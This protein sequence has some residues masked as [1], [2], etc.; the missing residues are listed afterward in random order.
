MKRHAQGL[1]VGLVCLAIGI[2]FRPI[3]VLI[4]SAVAHS[5]CPECE[6]RAVGAVAKRIQAER[7]AAYERAQ[8]AAAQV[9]SSNS[10]GAR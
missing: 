3:L 1:L 6:A 2:G 5:D 7:L 8:A 9:N 10:G 4:H